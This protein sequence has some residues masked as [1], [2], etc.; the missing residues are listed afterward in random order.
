MFSSCA[1]LSQKDFYKLTYLAEF[2]YEFDL[3]AD[4]TWTEVATPTRRAWSSVKHTLAVTAEEELQMDFLLSSSTIGLEDCYVEQGFDF[5]SDHWPVVSNYI[6]NTPNTLPRNQVN[7]CPV[8]WSPSEFWFPRVG[9]F[10]ADWSD[11]LSAFGQWAQIVRAK[12]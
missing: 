3:R 10:S 1:G 7:R 4:N 6:L 12:V 9:E 2:L 5:R 8:K 11:P